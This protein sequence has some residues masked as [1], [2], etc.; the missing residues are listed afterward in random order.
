MFR[1]TSPGASGT[2]SKRA[3][4]A[5]GP[6]AAVAA[7]ALVLGSAGAAT[8]Q[9][10]DTQAPT[11]PAALSAAPASSAIALNWSAST[12]NVGVKSYAV[13]R[14]P[15]AG[16]TWVN[17][18]GV[19]GRSYTDAAVTSGTQYTYG[20]RAVDAAGNVSQSS[21]LASAA[22][23]AG[24]STGGGTVPGTVL[25]KADGEQPLVNEWASL[26]TTTHCA[27]TLDGVSSDARISRVTS[28]V[29]K[30]T[31]AWG[32]TVND[33]DDCYGERAELGQAL[34]SRG[35]FTDARLF[36][37][38]DDRWIS[39]QVYLADDFPTTTGNWQVIAQWKQ[40]AAPG[41]PVSPMLALQVHNGA[42]Y[43][44]NSD[45]PTS[46]NSRGTVPY[47]LA[48]A[49]KGRW[50]KLSFHFKFSPDRNVGLAEVW[51]D[52][53]GA[54]VKQLL[55][56]THMWTMQLSNGAPVPSASRIGIYRNSAIN[57]TAHVYFDG[58]TVATTRGAAE[59]N[60]F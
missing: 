25:W 40:L 27:M 39:L 8:A 56:P 13:W 49:V 16:G 53:D 3:A 10:A 7:A 55:A 19:A 45:S 38:G 14:R 35:S 46:T 4:R 58:Y 24:G 47:R 26:S 6:L 44:E 18:A 34:P 20:V 17:V 31:G 23:G 48:G 28:P 60:A 9:A 2:R 29:A 22:P 52:V 21:N 59:A 5:A 15:A 41:G 11:A 37:N 42:F 51:G 57:G 12:D 33:G 50:A 32:F 1:N 36:N 30:G 43:L 54:G